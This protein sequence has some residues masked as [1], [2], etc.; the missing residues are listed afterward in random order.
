MEVPQGSILGPK[1]FILYVDDIC[2]V[3]KLVK[4][5]LF[6]DGTNMFCSANDVEQLDT[7]VCCELGKFQL[8]FSINKLSLNIAKANYI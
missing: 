7:I 2:N 8:C 4:F 5:I 3:S 6:A 1:L